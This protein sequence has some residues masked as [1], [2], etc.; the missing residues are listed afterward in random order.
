MTIERRKFLQQ[1]AA[2]ASAP[3]WL[4][5]T[6]AN[7]ATPP[8]VRYNVLSTPGQAMI[9][10][11]ARAVAIMKAKSQ[12]NPGDP[13]GW[14]FQWY[15]HAIPN[16]FADKAVAIQ[17]IY[18]GIQSPARALAEKAWWTCQPH[19]TGQ[20]TDNFLPWHRMFVLFFEQMIRETLSDPT[21]T[22]PYW[23]YSPG[24]PVSSASGIMPQAFRS[25][26]DPLLS[27]LYVEN[28]NPGV[29]TG[30]PIDTGR[31][32]TLSATGALSE[33]E[34]SP[35]LPIMGFCQNLNRNLHGNVHGLV[36]TGTNMGFVP[37]AGQ[38]PIFW[39][40]HCN[41]DRLWASWNK[42]GR[43]NPDDPTWAAQ[44]YTFAGSGGAAAEMAVG[45]VLNIA[46]PKL[47]YTYQEFEHVPG[48]L[49]N[50]FKLDQAFFSGM[51][52]KA[53]VASAKT[54]ASASGFSLAAAKSKVALQPAAEAAN[55]KLFNLALAAP[56]PGI[57]RYY[58]VI[59]DLQ[60]KAQPG[61]L[62]EL[63]LDLPENAAAAV[64]HEH[65]V[66]YLDFFDA[67]SG[68]SMDGEDRFLSFDISTL[69]KKLG[70][71]AASG[72]VNLTVLGG[73]KA[74]EGSEPSI[75]S[76]SIVQI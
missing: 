62:Y 6:F 55:N 39:M 14:T 63:F 61:V 47:N 8:L 21:F 73:E 58:L 53:P 38:D 40:H 51:S 36:G 27:S 44:R 49:N 35:D 68:M 10:K 23:N 18:G 57:G 42:A 50:A 33:T 30:R 3:L 1:A 16:S 56:A 4:R 75:G 7:A 32:G 12:A 69:V 66:G 29:N 19:R 52:R 28:R 46:D 9:R 13:T 22:L 60:I 34:Y 59:K 31:P 54:L 74:A 2:V 24:L 70:A 48:T 43:R 71:P 45:E 67:M 20:D 76:V 37:T 41:I 26:N 65:F 72:P 25:P 15:T 64:R 5:S 17:Q 11:Y